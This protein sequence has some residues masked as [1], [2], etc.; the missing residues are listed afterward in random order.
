M[1]MQTFQEAIEYLRIEEMRE[2]F[3]AILSASLKAMESHETQAPFHVFDSYFKRR[4]CGIS[5]GGPIDSDKVRVT[6][7]DFSK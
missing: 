5:L 7:H 6:L 1:A 4:P 2:N 3:V